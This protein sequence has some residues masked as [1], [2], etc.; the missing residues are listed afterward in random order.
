MPILIC[1]MTQQTSFDYI[2]T[3]NGLLDQIKAPVYTFKDIHFDK[4][5]VGELLRRW[6]DRKIWRVRYDTYLKE[7]RMRIKSGRQDA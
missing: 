2:Q 6:F 4:G 7:R 3:G 5:T 1:D